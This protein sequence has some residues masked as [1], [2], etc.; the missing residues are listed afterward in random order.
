[1]LRADDLTFAAILVLAIGLAM[2]ATA[3]AAS[4]GLAVSAVRARYVLLAALYFGGF[5]A[6]MPLVG[7]LVGASF[8]RFVIAW[9]H[10]I[11]FGMLA[12]IGGKMIHEAWSAE[13][14]APER[15]S[16]AQL[17]SHRALLLLAI[18][19]SIDALAAGVMLPVI[20]A[21]LLLSLLTIGVTTAVL[22][23]V[24]VLLGQRFGA[25]LG[26][27]LDVFGGLV[28]VGLGIKILVEHLSS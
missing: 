21:P 16:D 14:G 19:T 3:V 13:P 9:D 26:R 4:R 25:L 22:S 5:Q 8:G 15:S 18:A 27:R 10:W 17:F 7:W 12:A 11:A 20:G 6:L 23:A 2:D 1:M 24:G 28:L